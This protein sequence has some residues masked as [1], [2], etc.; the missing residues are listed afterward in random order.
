MPIDWFNPSMFTTDG[1]T[2]GGRFATQ[3]QEDYLI[4]NRTNRTAVDQTIFAAYITGEIGSIPTGGPISMA[5][6]VEYRKDEID[7]STEFLGSNGLVTAENPQQEGDSVG[8]RNLKE[9]YIE[10]VAPILVDMPGAQVFE[11]EAALR[12]T[13][14]SNFGSE[15]TG[16]FRAT[17]QIGR[18][19]CRERV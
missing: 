7:S 1:V 14:E 9:V 3:E 5:F 17:W 8:D 16:R 18:A 19:S 13:E 12:F 10:A 4:A 11:I 2:A 6:G 15:T